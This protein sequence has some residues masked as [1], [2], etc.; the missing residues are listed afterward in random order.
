MPLSGIFETMPLTELLQWLNITNKNGMLTVRAD[1]GETC[2][3]F[4]DG[5][6]VACGTG[7]MRED[8]GQLLISCGRIT[9]EDLKSV[10]DL[11]RATDATTREI[12]VSE[13]FIAEQEADSLLSE[14]AREAVY[15]LFLLGD[16]TRFYFLDE[17]GEPLHILGADFFGEMVDVRLSVKEIMMEGMIRIDEWKQIQQVFPPGCLLVPTEKAAEFA[18]DNISLLDRR[19]LECLAIGKRVEA[20][21]F[22]TRLSLFAAYQRMYSLYQRR[23]VEVKDIGRASSSETAAS[24]ANVFLK[25]GEYLLDQGQYNEANIVLSAIL[26]SD[27]FNSQAR[28][29]LKRSRG[30]QIAELYR[31]LSPLR[32]PRLTVPLERLDEFSLSPRETYLA[33][34]VNGKWDVGALVMISPQDELE[35]LKSLKKFAHIG[36]VEWMR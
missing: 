9:E 12:L 22:E 31:I 32:V 7:D 3:S 11:L 25:Q 4:E 36:L 2:L 5:E 33:S 16:E 13:G 35:T 15:N 21:C 6:I 20:V 19:I 14:N 24:G 18:K 10:Y 28:R 30:E 8:L 34:R 27:P 23:L 26:R 29:L 17:E 1:T